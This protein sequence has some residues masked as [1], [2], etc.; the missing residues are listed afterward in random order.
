[1]LL[2]LLLDAMAFN[3]SLPYLLTISRHGSFYLLTNLVSCHIIVTFI[4]LS[5]LLLL[6]LLLSIIHLLVF[7][8]I[9]AIQTMVITNYNM[10]N[11]LQQQI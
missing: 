3:S 1:M 10:T 7:F 5:S 8:V 4:R 6:L 11:Q 9:G 2:L